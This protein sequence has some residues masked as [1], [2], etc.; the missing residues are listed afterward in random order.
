MAKSPAHVFRPQTAVRVLWNTNSDTPLPPDVAAGS[1]PPDGAMI[2]YYIGSPTTAPVP[3][4]ITD[5]A[6]KLGRQ[7]SSAATLQTPDL[8][9]N[10]PTYCL[11]P[12]RR[13]SSEHGLNRSLR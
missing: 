6:D 5:E 3:P 13:L 12:P 2:D 10:I 1:N 11:S 8:A 4:E 9:L 7:Y